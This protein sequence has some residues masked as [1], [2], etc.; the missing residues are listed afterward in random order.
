MKPQLHDDEYIFNLTIHGREY[1]IDIKWLLHLQNE[2]TSDKNLIE[3]EETLEKVS[4]YL[5]TFSVAYEDYS[6]QKARLELKYDVWYKEKYMES[7][8]NL[9]NS[10]AEDIKTGV[11]SKTKATPTAAQ[12]EA[13]ITINNKD[14]YVNFKEK[15]NKIKILTEF[16][17]RE[18][19]ILEGRAGY[20][21]S[22]MSNRRKEMERGL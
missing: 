21:Q 7:E 19:K 10:F 3:L 11:R 16:L 20:I 14:E 18:M 8:K 4:G 5:H 12:I 1:A 13:N 17:W 22:I 15:L 9:I 6:R 2:I